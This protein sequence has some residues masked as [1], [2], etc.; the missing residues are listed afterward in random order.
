MDIRAMVRYP[1]RYMAEDSVGTMVII[2]TSKRMFGRREA[3]QCLTDRKHD[4][5]ELAS[6]SPS[7]QQA[8]KTRLTSEDIQGLLDFIV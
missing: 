5:L 2:S 1:W 3:R 6:A 4:S 8:P 7:G